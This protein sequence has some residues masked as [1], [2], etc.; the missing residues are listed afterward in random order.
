LGEE[1]IKSYHGYGM[2]ISYWPE[3]TKSVFGYWPESRWPERHTSILSF[4][5]V[6]IVT[7]DPIQSASEAENSNKIRRKNAVANMNYLK[8]KIYQVVKNIVQF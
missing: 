6:D 2:T 7:T 1:K 8:K 5:E 3:R 4:V